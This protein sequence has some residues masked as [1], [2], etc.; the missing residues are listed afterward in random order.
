M[1]TLFH[2]FT[3]MYQ[4]LSTYGIARWKICFLLVE[5]TTL[6]ETYEVHNVHRRR[7]ALCDELGRRPMLYILYII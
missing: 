6:F 2:Y 4:L 3:T 1:I 7:L 5:I